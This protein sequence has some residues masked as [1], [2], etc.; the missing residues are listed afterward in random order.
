M[1]LIFRLKLES[2]STDPSEIYTETS[3]HAF[4][5]VDGKPARIIYFI[6][7]CVQFALFIVYQLATEL[8]KEDTDWQFTYQCPDNSIECINLKKVNKFGWAMFS[9]VI[10]CFASP[11]VVMSLKQLERGIVDKE[12]VLIISGLVLLVL[13][14]TAIN[15][16]YIYNRALA[17]NNTDLILNAVILIFIIQLDDQIF[18]ICKKVRPTWTKGTVKK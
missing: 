17:E 13:M 12:P 4:I 5:F 11:D 10:I 6:S 14:I 9:I 3:V 15:I 1:T 16:S 2:S 7:I 8:N 18:I